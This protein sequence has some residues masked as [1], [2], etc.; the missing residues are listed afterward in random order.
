M[1]KGAAAVVALVA[2]AGIATTSFAFPGN[3]MQNN[4]DL[5]EQG[6]NMVNISEE[7][8][9]EWMENREDRRAERGDHREAVEDAVESGNY[10][11]WTEA[12]PE[13][14]P[15]AENINEDNFSKL[16]E[17]HEK[18]EGARSIMEEIGVE[19]GAGQMGCSHGDRGGMD[20]PGSRMGHPG[21]MR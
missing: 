6:K 15:M 13:S 2:V 14:C 8:R 5:A 20:H 4:E 18:R 17:A 21:Q 7:E 12:V 16:I 11:A 9:E 10:E 1:I 3:G 19:K